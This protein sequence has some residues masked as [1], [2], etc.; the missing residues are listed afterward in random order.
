[1]NKLIIG[2]MAAMLSFGAVACSSSSKS[3][4]TTV[5]S[6]SAATS[7]VATTTADA[8]TTTSGA[9]STGTSTAAP[10]GAV[11]PIGTKQAAV[12]AKTEAELTQAKA[13]FDVSCL[14]TLIAQLTDADADLILSAVPPATVLTSPAGEAL[15]AKLGSCV[16]APTG[17]VVST[18]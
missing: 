4:T 10:G 7:G 15:G 6:S 17:D 13:T 5:A 2:S 12:L 11:G 14:S 3:S 8:A 18:T 16:T 9:G 1:M